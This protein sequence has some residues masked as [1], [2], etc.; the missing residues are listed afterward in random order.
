MR[1]HRYWSLLICRYCWHF[2]IHENYGNCLLIANM[3][4]KC[5]YADIANA[6]YRHSPNTVSS[7]I[8]LGT[9]SEW[10]RDIRNF[11]DMEQSCFLVNRNTA[12]YNSMWRYS[13]RKADS[14]PRTCMSF[15]QIPPWHTQNIIKKEEKKR[16]KKKKKKKTLSNSIIYIRSVAQI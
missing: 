3:G 14:H 5:S 11:L 15:N 6:D 16:R 13:L 10:F 7:L 8:C 1:I 12:S 4:K 2:Q 9:S